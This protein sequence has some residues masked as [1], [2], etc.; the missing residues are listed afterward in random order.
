MPAQV[1]PELL[2][3][4]ELFDN[5]TTVQLKDILAACTEVLCTAGRVIIETGQEERA[6]YILLDG[7]VEVDVASPRAGDRQLA[8]LEK[9]SV[10]GESSFFHAS[11]HSTTVKALTDARLLRL[12][13]DQFAA[14]LQKDNIAAPP[15]RG[16]LREDSRRQAPA[17]RSLHRRTAGSLCRRED[18]RGLQPVPFVDGPLVQQ[19][20]RFVNDAR[21]PAQRVATALRASGPCGPDRRTRPGSRRRLRRARRWRFRPRRPGCRCPGARCR[22]GSC[23][24]WRRPRRIAGPCE[25]ALN[26]PPRSFSGNFDQLALRRRRALCSGA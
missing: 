14:L 23:R 18:S 6:L 22:G 2:H 24:S 25:A 16:E 19:W 17:S 9:G 10:F 21:W 12:D 11:P 15:R 8:Q 13:R 3:P 20:R 5:L 26:L 7:T 4:V 1:N